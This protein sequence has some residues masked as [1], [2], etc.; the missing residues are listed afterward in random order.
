[1]C[2]HSHWVLE[3]EAYLIKSHTLYFCMIFTLAALEIMNRFQNAPPDLEGHQQPSFFV[4][5][6]AESVR[7]S[8]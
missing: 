2:L 7:S 6:E 4:S 8:P 3:V 5:G 1:M